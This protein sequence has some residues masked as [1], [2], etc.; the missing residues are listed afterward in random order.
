MKITPEDY[1]MLSNCLDAVM[2]NVTEE[3]KEDYLK[4]MEANPKV[5]NPLMCLR[6]EALGCVNEKSNFKLLTHLYHYLN[7]DTIDTALR[8]YFNHS[9]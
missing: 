4:R 9:K 2:E 6:W 1:S 3:A 5:K 7:D 8:R